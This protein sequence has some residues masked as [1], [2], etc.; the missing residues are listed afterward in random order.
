MKLSDLSAFNT[1]WEGPCRGP[2]SLF[3]SGMI[4]AMPLPGAFLSCFGKK[5]S[6]EAAPRGASSKCAPLGIPRRSGG[7]GLGVSWVICFYW[8][9][10]LEGVLFSLGFRVLKVVPRVGFGGG[11]KENDCLW[12]SVKRLG[13]SVFGDFWGG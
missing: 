9:P 2:S 8:Q 3:V 12:Q 7:G 1:N 10:N 11:Y 4:Q 5:G 6:K 13:E